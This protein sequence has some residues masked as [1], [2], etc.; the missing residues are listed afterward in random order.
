MDSMVWGSARRAP[1]K[2]GQEQN[3]ATAAKSSRKMA[4]V[5]QV[6]NWQSIVKKLCSKNNRIKKEKNPNISNRKYYSGAANLPASCI[7]QQHRRRIPPSRPD[8]TKTPRRQIVGSQQSP[9]TEVSIFLFYLVARLVRVV[10]VE[11]HRAVVHP[12][13]V[14]AGRLLTHVVK[15]VRAAVG[16][17]APRPGVGVR[18]V[19]SLSKVG[20]VPIFYLV[21]FVK[22]TQTSVTQVS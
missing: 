22:Q 17:G 7:S 12:A 8:G 6:V 20:V 18:R 5:Q 9:S 4:P 1:W 21:I 16:D 14:R 10:P 3:L 15:P 19:V 2:M 11:S 13:L